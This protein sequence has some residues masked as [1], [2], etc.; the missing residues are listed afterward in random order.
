MT[1]TF[2]KAL[3]AYLDGGTAIH[4]IERDDGRVETTETGW[5]FTPFEKWSD[6]EKEVAGHAQGRVLEVGCGGGRISKHLESMGLEVIGID[7]SPLAL[8]AAR[9]YG[10]SDCRLMDAR[11]LDF[12]ENYF[13][14]ASLLGNGLGLG[15]DVDDS[16]QLLSNLS[17]AVRPG[18]VLLASSINATNTEE[19]AHL[20][21]HDMNRARGKPAGLVRIRVNF[22]DLKGDW[23]DLLFLDLHEI[24]PVVKGTGWEVVDMVM[25]DDPKASRYGVVLGNTK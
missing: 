25:P 4:E 11:E 19:P 6:V 14:T 12:P 5:Y 21:Y 24:K 8:E 15:G 22:E 3:I 1:D 10:A 20:A 9:R 16:R 17:R 23:F 2:G 18:G 7:I 13:D